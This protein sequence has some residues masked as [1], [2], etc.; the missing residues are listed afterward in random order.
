MDVPYNHDPDAVVPLPGVGEALDR[1]RSAGIKLGIVTN[2]RGVALGR[3]S[4]AQLRHV[5]RRVEELLGPFDVIVSCP[6]DV[7]DGCECRKPRPGLVLDAARRLGV[8][9]AACAVVGDSW[10]DVDAACQAGATAFLIDRD[11]TIRAGSDATEI[12]DGV[13][14]VA[15]FAAA[16]DLMLERCVAA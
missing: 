13:T 1:A 8:E 2:Q 6:H 15:D 16:V 3:I 5:H 10:S 14:V 9:P 4:P 11:G 12:R 7:D